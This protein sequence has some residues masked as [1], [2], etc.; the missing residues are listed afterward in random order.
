MKKIN[1]LLGSL[2]LAF[3]TISCDSFLDIEP[4]GK[5]IPKTQED[6]RALLTQGYVSFPGHKSLTSLR[7]DELILDM[8][9]MDFINLKDIYI[10]KD[11]SQ[12]KLTT[13]F[14]WVAFYTSV[15]YANHCIIEGSKILPASTEKEQLLGEAYALRAYAF[16]D[17]V[18]LYAK[19]YQ[20]ATAA[21]EKAIPLALELDLE[22]VLQPESTQKV[23]QQIHSDLEQAKYYLQQDTQE[24]GMRYRFSKA[25]TLALE[26]RVF[27]YQQKWEDARSSALKA[28][29]YSKELED[30]NY[31]HT[32]PTHF[33]S[34][35]AI[36][37]LE[38]PFSSTLKRSTFASESLLNAYD[39]K[40]DLRYAA[41]FEKD[42]EHYK[43]KKSGETAMKSSIRT[44]ELYFILAET[45]ARLHDLK[46]AKETLSTIIK[47]R[48]TT[49]G[50][51]IILNKMQALDQATFISFLLE[52]RR[53]EFSMEGQRWFDLRRA[54]QK[55]LRHTLN[56][57]D[58]ILQE[59]D[60]R[61][62]LPYPTNAR[63]NNPNL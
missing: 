48:Y 4:E 59:N 9:S 31:N 24:G 16:F 36:L 51:E 62:T 18:N 8:Q 34:K 44:A 26:A 32:L 27:L 49:E 40:Q 7:T 54:N 3:S 37:A 29:S 45:E 39:A 13:E 23:Y 28:M 57:K 21:T 35:E 12:D 52:E 19:P 30:F 11:Q 22:K 25:A 63:L 20:E 33:Q 1:L 53:K 2:L 17:L 5:I 46:N 38:L 56:G 14:P 10:W 15:F 42:G 55:E 41:Y 60:P 47:T 50:A 58:Y 6:F 61:Y 43:V